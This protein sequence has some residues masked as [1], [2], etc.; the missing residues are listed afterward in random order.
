MAL[1]AMRDRVLSLESEAAAL[2]LALSTCSSA[3]LRVCR[4]ECLRPSINTAAVGANRGPPCRVHAPVRQ[5]VWAAR[6]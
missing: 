1:A 5:A 6:M 4:R 2:Q 3:E